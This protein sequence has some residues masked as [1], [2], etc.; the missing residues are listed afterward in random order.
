[1][2]EKKI[3]L[4]YIGLQGFYWV[5]GCITGGFI[6]FYLEGKG[7]SG[8]EIGISTSIF[9]L[10]TFIAQPLLGNLCDRVQS[11]TWKK[12][13]II[14]GIPYIAVAVGMLI[15]K[16]KLSGA[17]FFGVLLII[18]NAILPLV[19]TAMFAYQKN[20]IEI[21]FGVARGTGSATYAVTALIIGNLAVKTGVN[22]VPVAGIIMMI[23]LLLLTLTMPETYHKEE[24]NI[25]AKNTDAIGFIKKYPEFA[26]MLLAV[27]FMFFSHN[28]IG[29]YLLQIIES[30]GGNSV[31][32]GRAL[33]VQAIVEIP[34]LFGF[35]F[36]LKKFK[37][38]NLMII[39]GVG[40]FFKA[41]LYFISKNIGM[42]YLA[43]IGQIFSFAILAAA[44]VYFT[45]III[46]LEDQTTGQAFMSSMS[47]AGTVLGSLFGGWLIDYMGIKALLGVNIIASV[48]G[49]V[50]AAYSVMLMKKRQ[51][52]E[53][54]L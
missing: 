35:I 27:L 33:F 28:I 18:T 39:A 16:D 46:K 29:V 54:T 34:V 17:I 23:A 31:H 51:M 42:I 37:V 41:I 49:V 22:I 13:I 1:M 25:N 15:L 19:N 47:S 11:L 36:L 30:L 4:Q 26:I 44:S 20:G 24:K 7:L 48:F 12:L 3:N 38:S 9:C 40:Y 53:F 10:I 2:S 8:S 14:L 45:G 50:V 21:N 32:L 43:Q 52:G 5:L 6:S